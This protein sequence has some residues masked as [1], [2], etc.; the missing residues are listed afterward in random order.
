MG[1]VT[2]TMA[3]VIAFL[4]IMVPFAIRP[5]R[6]DVQETMGFVRMTELVIVTQVSLEMIVA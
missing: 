4:A 2:S 1:H 5:V 6:D 3:L